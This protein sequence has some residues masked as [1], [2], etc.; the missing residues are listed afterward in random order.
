MYSENELLDKRPKELLEIIL[1]LQK[2][3]AETKKMVGILGENQISEFY[4]SEVI[5]IILDTTSTPMGKIRRV[6]DLFYND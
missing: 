6:M 3:L 1:S 2:D 4:I 5:K